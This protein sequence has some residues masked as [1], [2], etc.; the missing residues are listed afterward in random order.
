MQKIVREENYN[1]D[2]GGKIKYLIPR[3]GGIVRRNLFR[4]KYNYRL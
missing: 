1:T 4:R 3:D 2:N